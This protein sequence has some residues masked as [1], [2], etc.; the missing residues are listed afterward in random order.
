MAGWRDD[1]TVRD[2]D[3]YELTHELGRLGLEHGGCV[4]QQC[5]TVVL[6]EDE[7]GAGGLSAVQLARK[8]VDGSRG[9]IGG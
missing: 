5:M 1:D 7:R 9:E 8:R 2:A 6:D 3:R 4:R